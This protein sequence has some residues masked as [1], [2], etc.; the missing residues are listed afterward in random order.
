[1]HH[2]TSEKRAGRPRKPRQVRSCS[3]CGR[4]FIPADPRG[5]N[6]TCPGGCGNGNMGLTQENR[7]PDPVEPAPPAENESRYGYVGWCG[8]ACLE[9]GC[10][11]RLPNG[12]CVECSAAAA[13]KKTLAR[14]KRGRP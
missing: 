13:L 11:V 10:K 7:P 6:K 5:R 1:M 2:A 8:V 3:R 12:E 4:S 9:C 14:K